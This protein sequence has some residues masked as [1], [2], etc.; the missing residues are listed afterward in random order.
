MEV[1]LLFQKH[2]SF[3][4]ELWMSD[5]ELLLNRMRGIGPIETYRYDRKCTEKGNQA[6]SRDEKLII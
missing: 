5:D 6:N 1:S 4:I 2:N 3:F